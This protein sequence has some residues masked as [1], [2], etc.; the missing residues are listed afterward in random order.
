MNT[1]MRKILKFKKNIIIILSENSNLIIF[2]F[3][4]NANQLV[5][6]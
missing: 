6:N 2:F 5:V 1:K 4:I 3:L